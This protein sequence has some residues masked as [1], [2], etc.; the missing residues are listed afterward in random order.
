VY[1][2]VELFALILLF[3]EVLVGFGAIGIGDLFSDA[4]LEAPYAFNV[5]VTSMR[6]YI[7]GNVNHQLVGWAYQSWSLLLLV[8]VA[9]RWRQRQI[10]ILLREGTV[11]PIRANPNS[12]QTPP[13]A[14]AAAAPPRPTRATSPPALSPSSSLEMSTLRQ[15]STTR[16]SGVT[17]EMP[18]PID[19]E[20]PAADGRRASSGSV[21]EVASAA[22]RRLSNLARARVNG[23]SG[24]NNSNSSVVS[25]SGG[26][27]RNYSNI[28]TRQLDVHHESSQRQRGRESSADSSPKTGEASP[29]PTNLL[30][31]LLM[32]NSHRILFYALL[33]SIS[34]AALPIFYDTSSEV[35]LEVTRRLH[36]INVAYSE[37]AGGGD[38]NGPS[39]CSALYYALTD[40]GASY[41]Y[42]PAVPAYF[43]YRPFDRKTPQ[44]ELP[45]IVLAEILPVRCP[46]QLG[47]TGLVIVASCPF[48]QSGIT[49][50]YP[51]PPITIP[52][53][54]GW[55][56]EDDDVCT[57]N[58]MPRLGPLLLAG[59]TN[60]AL[61]YIS[62]NSVRNSAVAD[63]ECVTVF[64]KAASLA[65]APITADCELN[66]VVSAPV[67]KRATDPIAAVIVSN[68]PA[69]AVFNSSAYF[70]FTST[71]AFAS[72]WNLV[73][74]VLLIGVIIVA[75]YCLSCV[76]A[77]ERASER[78]SEGGQAPKVSRERP[79][80]GGTC[81]SRAKEGRRQ[82]YL[83]SGRARAGRAA[84]GRRAGA[85]SISRA[86]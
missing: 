46:F 51:F 86:A 28:S 16:K 66:K 24:S 43:P 39:G 82:K 54:P 47:P 45:F 68:I 84:R 5:F 33:L 69:S 8:G 77:G 11:A 19:E 42:P 20:S 10:R 17:F 21:T 59:D 37:G 72:M 35:E 1:I 41:Y 50:T 40:W 38:P 67:V 6:Q 71:V 55:I 15:R 29:V 2:L 53:Q 26:T 32:H 78:A 22:A 57:A 56:I 73:G 18:P 7:T 74:R 80:K 60:A 83:E 3:L 48:S 31:A 75:M 9:R 81:R 62:D 13:A 14:V 58:V 34:L 4:V 30:T 79:S 65:G 63:G 23:S 44:N 27:S 61:S 85:E 64:N 49:L 25:S 52:K 36:A 70:N 12:S 76:P